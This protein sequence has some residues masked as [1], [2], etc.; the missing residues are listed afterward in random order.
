MGVKFSTQHFNQR[1]TNEPTNQD[2]FHNE[3]H[4]IADTLVIAT[5]GICRI[6][7]R[8]VKKKDASRCTRLAAVLY[9]GYYRITGYYFKKP[10]PRHGDSV[11]VGN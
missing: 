11:Y 9:L 8:V 4:D 3:W 7:N 2:R 6:R 5:I 10:Y 1:S